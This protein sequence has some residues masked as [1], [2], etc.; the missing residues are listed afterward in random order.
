MNNENLKEPDQKSNILRR[1][2]Y[3]HL[4]F[5]NALR[6]HLRS[7]KNYEEIAH[8]LDDTE[9]NRI[10]KLT[11]KPTQINADQT[12]D[13]KSVYKKEYLN[14]FDYIQLN[15]TLSQFYDIQGGCERI[16]NTVFPRLYAY[17][18]TMLTWVFSFVLIF[19]LVDE[20]QWQTM[21]VRMVVAYVF[22]ILDDLG[23]RLKNPF[24]NQIDDTPMTALCRVIEIDLRE[25]IGDKHDLK[26][27]QPVKGTLY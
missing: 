9:Y 2:V 15:A 27:L 22:L 10:I 11:N 7:G 13:L 3:R 26:P 1:F 14:S 23:R 4:A 5:I 16:K 24:E 12:R 18:T 19:S 20:F 25:M 6:I 17:Y 21:I 8:Y